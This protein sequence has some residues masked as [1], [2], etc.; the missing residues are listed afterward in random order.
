MQ[1]DS[2]RRSQGFAFFF[3]R[4]RILCVCESDLISECSRTVTIELGHGSQTFGQRVFKLTDIFQLTPCSP[5]CMRLLASF[6]SEFIIVTHINS[7][8]A[9]SHCEY[10]PLLPFTIV[11]CFQCYVILDASR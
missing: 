4:G 8:T 2:D 10:K 5:T 11:D 3:V 7:D 1:W 6:S 9:A